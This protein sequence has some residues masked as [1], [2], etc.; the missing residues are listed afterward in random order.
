MKRMNRWKI[1]DSIL[2]LIIMLITL[3]PSASAAKGPRNSDLLIKYYP[4]IEEAYQALKLS[5]IDILGYELTT[6]LYADAIDDPN[7]CLG[8]VADSGMYEFDLNS[9]HTIRSYRGIESFIYGKKRTEV[10]KAITY[11]VD[12]DLIVSMCAG[13]FAERIDQGLTAPDKGWGNQTHPGWGTSDFTYDYNPDVAAAILDAA[14][15]V[16]GSTPNPAYDP[17]LSWSA[18]FL[19]V[20][21]EDHPTHAGQDVHPIIMAVRT[22]DVRRYCAGN[23]LRYHLKT[24]GFKTD[25]LYGTSTEL[26]DPVMGNLD[27][28]IYTGGWSLGRFPPI[29]QYGLYH[30]GNYWPY[31]S[32]YITGRDENGNPNFPELDDDLEAGYTADTYTEARSA[33]RASCGHAWFDFCINVPLYSSASFWAWR[34]NVKGV[35]NAE[36][37]GPQNGYSFMNMYKTDESSLAY[38]TRSP[39]VAMNIIFSGWYYDYQSL[40]R[41]N[42]YGGLSVAPY[43]MSVDQA[44]FVKDWETGTYIDYD[45]GLEQ[46]MNIFS[47]RS[48]TWAVEPVSGN[49]VENYNATQVY[50]SMWYFY[51][52]PICWDFVLVEDI[53]HLNITE[54]DCG[55]EVYWCTLS[56]WN[57]YFGGVPLL[58]FDLLRN[59]P[60]SSF[61]TEDIAW[62]GGSGMDWVGLSNPDVFWIERNVTLNGVPLV[63][64][65]DYEIYT[66]CSSSGGDADM[67]LIKPTAIGTLHVE[68]WVAGDARGYTPGN[69]AW[70]TSFQGAGMYYAVDFQPGENGYLALRRNPFYYMETPPLGEVDFERKPTGCQKIDIF[71]IVLAASAYGS[72]GGSIPDNEWLPG[73]DL[74]PDCC[75]VDIFDLVTVTGK[76][77][78]EWDC[79]PS[80]P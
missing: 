23:E 15:F 22:D 26:Y 9:N 44:G 47:Y 52:T 67:R 34:C 64:G 40:D 63:Q 25:D 57:T 18:E 37:A 79:P 7:I 24:I 55:L 46:S 59:Y 38:G 11:L 48:D 76:Y 75:R 27:F 71:D 36:G 21:P 29:Y 69:I 45:S 30:S 12:K 60:L 49:Q 14:G 58:S 68:Y 2:I 51:Q 10:R 3:Y 42:L 80:C 70:Q 66:P 8:K 54:D 41:M 16:Q 28:H 74:V 56:Y 35:V 39:P 13:G 65:V 20:Y 61:H 43:D 78:E 50:Q 4:G 31:D 19:R 5:E 1:V 6:S 17:A 73:A 32:N 77:G 62:S 53:D 33:V 72:Q